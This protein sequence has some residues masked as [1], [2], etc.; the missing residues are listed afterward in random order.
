MKVDGISS[1]REG[2]PIIKKL[3]E[4]LSQLTVRTLWIKVLITL[5]STRIVT[6]SPSFREYLSD[7]SSDRE[8]PF[9]EVS[10]NQL[11]SII[12]F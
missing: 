5:L 3:G 11:P 12:S 1:N 10:E 7:I 9:S 4:K 2:C 8:I 6:S